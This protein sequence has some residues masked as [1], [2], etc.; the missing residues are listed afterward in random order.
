MMFVGDLV[1]EMQCKGPHSKTEQLGESKKMGSITEEIDD[2]VSHEAAIHPPEMM[3]NVKL[4]FK[5][6]R[7]RRF[8]N[9][10]GNTNL[11]QGRNIPSASATSLTRPARPKS[12]TN[13]GYRW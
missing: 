6:P 2:D 9:I 1:L 13:P 3:G 10:S 8:I 12:P 11:N 5:D 7:S 4:S